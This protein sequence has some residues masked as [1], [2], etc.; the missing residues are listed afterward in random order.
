MKMNDLELKEMVSYIDEAGQKGKR[1]IKKIISEYGDIEL[2]SDE[3]I[4]RFIDM[5]YGCNIVVIEVN[6]DGWIERDEI[7]GVSTRKGE[8]SQVYIKLRNTEEWINIY[9]NIEIVRYV[10]QFIRNYFF[11]KKEVERELKK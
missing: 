8:S 7:V 3:E 10:L 4:D 11:Y 2:K 6:C 1:L 9:D 5:G